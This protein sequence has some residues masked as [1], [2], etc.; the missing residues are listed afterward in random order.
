LPVLLGIQIRVCDSFIF[1]ELSKNQRIYLIPKPFISTP[2]EP[3]ESAAILP[4]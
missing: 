2:F 1:I 3:A 4:R